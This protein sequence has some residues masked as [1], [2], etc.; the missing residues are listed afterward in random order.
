M[1]HTKTITLYTIDE[2]DKTTRDKALD[3][4]RVNYLDYDWW[5]LLFDDFKT[6]GKLIGIDIDDIYFSGFGS[7]GDGACFTG[8]YAY[9]KGALKAIK[10]YAPND[11]ELH[12]IAKTLQVIQ[13]PY[14]YK[15][16]AVVSHRGHYCH[17]QCND[18]DVY[19]DDGCIYSSIPNKAQEDL[20]YELRSYMKWMY[21]ALEK[22][23]YYLL[24]DEAMI[25]NCQTND[26]LFSESGELE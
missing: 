26:Y 10:E 2:L 22:E 24:S 23:Y 12:D 3:N 15:L 4:L 5:D 21:G 19:K 16:T 6:V 17:E 7:Q 11:K 20:S 25:E 13:K 9:N 18:I 8:S 14:F 1:S